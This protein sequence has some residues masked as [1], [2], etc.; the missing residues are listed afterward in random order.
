MESRIKTLLAHGDDLFT[1][2]KPLDSLNQDIAE[3]F[4]PPRADFIQTFTLGQ[5]FMDGLDTS[6]PILA[7]REL[8]TAFSAMLRPKEEQWFHL[9]PVSSARETIPAL[10]WLQD[11]ESLM[12]R[13][14]Y[15]RKSRFVAAT[16][17][18]DADY[19]AFGSPVISV[20]LNRAGDGLLY[21]C[22]H[23]RDVV[24]SEDAEGDIG[25]IQRKWKPTIR[26]LM[27]LF[28]KTVSEKVVEAAKKNPFDTVECR[29]IVVCKD[30]Y[31]PA[32]GKKA[33]KEKYVS[34]Y[35]ESETG[36]ILEEVPSRSKIYVIPRWRPWPGSQYAYSPA[37]IAALPDAR[38]LQAITGTLI[39]VSERA[40]NPPMIAVE[41][42]IKSPIDTLP[43]GVSIADADYDE[44]LGEVLRPLTQDYRGINYGLELRNDTRTMIAQAFYL[45]RLNLP[46][47]AGGD[48]MTA[49]EVS[50]RVQEY[51]RR[52]I[53]L[54]EPVETEYNGGLC[55]ETFDLL[56]HNGAFGPLDAMPQELRS[57]DL[58]FRFESPLHTLI[59]QAKGQTF[60]QASGLVGEAV[61]IDAGA[62]DIPDVKTA[63]RDALNGIGAPALWLR[64]PQE[65]D[66][67]SQQKQAQ[68]LQTA[69]L[70][71]A[72]KGASAIKDSSVAA[73]NFASAQ[74]VAP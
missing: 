43:G 47:A 73:K 14:M 40:A 27:Q 16:S 51:I 59:E 65:S 66:A 11:K 70:E 19:A 46:P 9:K 39:E 22:W 10:R 2:R 54:F 28:P 23:L 34:L 64:S 37:V 12:R 44:R 32:L 3:N 61:K 20:E 25:H 42:M 72:A 69:Q 41:N 45:D 24:W 68:A 55:E 13:A 29:H 21:R 48:K 71:A 74:T 35:I 49:F 62:A 36:Q 33:S 50:Q 7:H 1:K 15:D 6:G 60:L 26:V 57:A 58:Q 63:L 31:E 17:E 4:Y 18:G 53:P 38:L 5:N 56:L 67:I 52:A 8:S 30:D